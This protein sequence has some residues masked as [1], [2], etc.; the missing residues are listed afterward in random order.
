MIATASE[1]ERESIF[2]QFRFNKLGIWA[3]LAQSGTE[4]RRTHTSTA[5]ASKTNRHIM[6]DVRMITMSPQRT[7]IYVRLALAHTHTHR[8]TATRTVPVRVPRLRFN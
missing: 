8:H 5:A 6:N 1:R 2:A 3:T 4:T 7:A